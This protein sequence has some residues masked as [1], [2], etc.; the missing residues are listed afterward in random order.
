[1]STSKKDLNSSAKGSEGAGGSFV[2]RG[3]GLEPTEAFARGS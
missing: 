3:V 2:V 1:M